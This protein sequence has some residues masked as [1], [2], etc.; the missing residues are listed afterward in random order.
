MAKNN[1]KPTTA[2]DLLDI[3]GEN[4]QRLRD[5]QATPATANAIVNSSSAMLR[6][7]KLQMDYAKMTGRRPSIPMLLTPNASEELQA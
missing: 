3:L 6:V 5:G 7:V 2:S 4:I 1:G